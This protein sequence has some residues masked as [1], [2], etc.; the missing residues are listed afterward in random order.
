MK[1]TQLLVLFFSAIGT[2]TMQSQSIIVKKE[3]SKLYDNP[4]NKE[5]LKQLT[6]DY[7][8]E[9]KIIEH[10]KLKDTLFQTEFAANGNFYQAQRIENKTVIYYQTHNFES[11]NLS[12][13][14]QL[15]SESRFQ[16]LKGQ[17]MWVGIIDG[18]LPF[19]RHVEF[20]TP[21]NSSSRLLNRGE[22][23]KIENE[24]E[25]N[26]KAIE[27]R[28]SHATHVL[29]T[30]LA[31]GKRDVTK[32]MA[33]EAKA[34]GYSWGNDMEKLAELAL[35]G[36]LVTNQ[37]YGLALLGANKEVL[38]PSDYLGAYVKES[39]LLDQLAYKPQSFH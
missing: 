21:F 9:N 11:R 37:S 34:I 30:I 5:L 31:Q 36:V 16:D 32:G 12:G 6:D 14:N 1:I 23:K 29:G 28:R 35:E 4:K 13:L 7:I 15:Q 10:L 18:D 2:F 33:P 38:L 19:D 27:N 39:A 3:L 22:W 20:S 26:H 17:N 25:D 24:E 8:V